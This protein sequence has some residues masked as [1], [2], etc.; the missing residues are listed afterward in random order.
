M[1]LKVGAQI[2]LGFSI[3]LVIL[4]L[5]G[6][7]SYYQVDTISKNIADIERANH[8]KDA[9]AKSQ[10]SYLEAAL[11]LRGYIAYGT[12]SYIKVVDDEFKFALITS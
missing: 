3:I 7:Y 11:A 6:G 1:R 4:F 10:R 8:R 2:T 5:V 12:E 9:M